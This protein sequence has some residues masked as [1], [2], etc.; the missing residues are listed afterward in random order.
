MVDRWVH[1]NVRDCFT[2]RGVSEGVQGTNKSNSKDLD[3]CEN[4]PDKKRRQTRHRH[5]R[6]QST[7]TYK[8]LSNSDLTE[9]K[10]LHPG[11]LTESLL[12]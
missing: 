4:D 2:I 11:Q 10:V 5:E 9:K 12:L 6:F 1:W 7:H 8:R 3:I